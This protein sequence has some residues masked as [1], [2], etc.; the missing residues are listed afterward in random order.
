MNTTFR[1]ALVISCII[2][3]VSI[4][5]QFNAIVRILVSCIQC[6]SQVRCLICSWCIYIR[7]KVNR[8]CIVVCFFNS[9][10]CWFNYW[11]RCYRCNNRFSYIG[12]TTETV[13][14]TSCE[15]F[16]GCGVIICQAGV[17][18][19][20]TS[21]EVKVISNLVTKACFPQGSILSTYST[22]SVCF[23][24]MTNRSFCYQAH[25]CNIVV[26]SK[27]IAT[28]ISPTS[29]SRY[30][31]TQGLNHINFMHA[32]VGITILYI[33]TLVIVLKSCFISQSVGY[34]TIK[35]PF[36]IRR[37]T[38]SLVFYIRCPQINLSLTFCKSCLRCSTNHGNAHSCYSCQSE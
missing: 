30:V 28:D 26:M 7:I 22:F 11:S 18:L 25:L 1:Q 13:R 24:L 10:G 6:C 31:F 27:M 2:R 20:I 16:E 9:R 37:N 36:F 15:T 12:V 33:E 35:V 17:D 8:S 4:P 14:Q 34:T 32:V 29:I 3:G 23:Q 21:F 5:Y 19:F 38:C